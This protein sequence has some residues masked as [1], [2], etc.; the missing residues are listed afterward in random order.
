[1][2]FD[3]ALAETINP[4]ARYWEIAIFVMNINYVGDGA[5]CKIMYYATVSANHH[6]DFCLMLVLI[7]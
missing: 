5:C 7:V 6:G 2:C 1:M 3:L 4:Y